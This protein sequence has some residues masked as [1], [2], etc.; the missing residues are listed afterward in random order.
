MRLPVIGA[1]Q[2]LGLTQSEARAYVALLEAEEAQGLTG[3]ELAGRS[4]VPRS[5]VY[6]VLGRLEELG[7]VFRAGD[8]PVRFVPS[9][10]E[11][12]VAHCR[13]ATEAR[14]AQAAGQ[15][16]TL[17]KRVRPEP[18]WIVSRYDEV[19]QAAEQLLRGARTSVILSLWLRELDRLAPALEAVAAR[20]G[21]HRVLHGADLGSRELPG[22]STWGEDVDLDPGKARWSH[23][24]IIVVDHEQALVGGA[25]PEADNQAVRTSNPAL[26]DLATNHVILDVTRIA[27]ASGRSCAH[28]VSPMMRTRS[29]S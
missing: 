24:L 9:A 22:F 25:E 13:Q 1:L 11:R 7:A 18:V 19:L 20:L 5:A 14:L 27:A 16:A 28:V 17:P 23:K 8:Q 4:G 26:V 15:L 2:E 12:F 6:T 10:P 29:G 3:Y 21:L